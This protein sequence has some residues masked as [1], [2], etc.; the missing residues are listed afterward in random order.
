M[1]KILTLTDPSA[2][3]L[4]THAK[5]F[6]AVAL[7]GPLRS[8]IIAALGSPVVPPTGDA[9]A[10]AVAAAAAAGLRL[11]FYA[12]DWASGLSPATLL[13]HTIQTSNDSQGPGGAGVVVCIA[14]T[15]PA[16]APLGGVGSISVVGWPLTAT[17][18]ARTVAISTAPCDFAPHPPSNPPSLD[19]G[20]WVKS[21]TDIAAGF[22]VGSGRAGMF[23]PLAQ[24]QR[25]F[26]NV[27]SGDDVRITLTAP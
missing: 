11:M 9:R 24:G 3:E 22:R 7:S 5:A 14:F 25:Y 4:L 10:Q 21:G 8:E 12:W 20:T 26:I 6:G 2:A 1:S 19:D 18:V 13:P 15:V 23:S 17:G 16:A 27:L